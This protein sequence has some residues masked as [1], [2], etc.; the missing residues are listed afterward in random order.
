MCDSDTQYWFNIDKVLLC[1]ML[2]RNSSWQFYDQQL[3]DMSVQYDPMSVTFRDT[4]VVTAPRANFLQFRATAL[5]TE[6]HR[7]IHVVLC[8]GFIMSL[9]LC[10]SVSFSA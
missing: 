9:P 10:S 8:N 7:V 1:A 3:R 2:Q 4:L 6:R 5:V